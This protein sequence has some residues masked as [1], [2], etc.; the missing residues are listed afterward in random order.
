[1]SINDDYK[2]ALSI[3]ISLFDEKI[4]TLDVVKHGADNTTVINA[5]THLKE[6]YENFEFR[7]LKRKENIFKLID[8]GPVIMGFSGIDSHWT[9]ITHYDETHFYLLDSSNYTKFKIDDIQFNPRRCD[10]SK[11]CV[12]WPDIIALHAKSEG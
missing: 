7:Q 4:V 8:K 10:E 11:I 1:M 5:L 6:K 9:V 12:A 3:F 2:N